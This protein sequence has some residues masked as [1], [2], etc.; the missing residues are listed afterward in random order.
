LRSSFRLSFFDKRLATVRSTQK[1]VLTAQEPHLRG[2]TPE[3]NRDCR[4]SRKPSPQHGDHRNNHRV[5]AVGSDF[6][7]TA[8]SAMFF[9]S[10]P[11]WFAIDSRVRLTYSQLNPSF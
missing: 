3:G 9:A 11:E 8:R 1:R 4:E 6:R 5:L 2:Q 10:R 7:S